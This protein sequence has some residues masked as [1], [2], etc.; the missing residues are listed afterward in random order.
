M[1]STAADR[2]GQ[3]AG[4]PRHTPGAGLAQLRELWG[5]RVPEP[6]PDVERQVDDLIERAQRMAGRQAA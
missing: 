3:P 1:T 4:P 5:D 2:D 6:V